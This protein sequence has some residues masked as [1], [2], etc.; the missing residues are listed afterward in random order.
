M[1][2]VEREFFPRFVDHA[3]R[4][5]PAA[6]VKGIGVAFC[7]GLFVVSANHHFLMARASGEQ[8]FVV[9]HA[10]GVAQQPALRAGAAAGEGIAVIAARAIEVGAVRLIDAGVV[11]DVG[12][13][14]IRRRRH[15][16]RDFFV[17]G[18]R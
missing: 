13:R 15:L 9:Q 6:A 5:H 17:F 12:D 7:T 14:V 2:G 8:Q 3:I 1:V 10:E 11:I 4:W 16:P 18:H